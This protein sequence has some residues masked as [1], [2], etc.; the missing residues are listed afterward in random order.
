MED[1]QSPGKIAILAG[2][3]IALGVFFDYLFYDKPPGI[4]FLIFSIIILIALA[5]IIWLLKRPFLAS[6]W[7]YAIPIVFFSGMVAIREAYFLSFLNI[8]LT[9][10]LFLLLVDRT[11]GKDLRA[12]A[13][14][15]YLAAGAAL[16]LKIIGSAIVGVT[17]VFAVRTK[18]KGHQALG[19]VVRGVLLA[20][21]V[22]IILLLLFASADLIFKKYLTDLFDIQIEAETFFY[23]VRILFVGGVLFG[24]FRIIAGLQH[25]S[26]QEVVSSR[27]KRTLGMI[28]ISVFLGII[29]AAFL[30][31]IAVQLA[32]L[33]GGEHNIAVQGYTYAEY[34]RKGFF[35]LIAAAVLT[36]LALW[37]AERSIAKTEEKHARVFQ[38]L[39]AGLG[40]Q[41]F[42]MMISAF[43][44]LSL[45]EQAYG[46]TNLRLYSHVA[47]VWI[48]CIFVFL[49]IHI[50]RNEDEPKFAFRSFVSVLLF[51]AFL[52][53]MN[54]DAFIARKN[55]E[56]FS[57]SGKLDASYLM[58]LSSDAVPE[59]IKI[60]D[61][62][63]SCLISS[64]VQHLREVGEYWQSLNLSRSNALR[65][66]DR[67]PSLHECPSE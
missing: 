11:F 52:N 53:F 15:N 63:S 19:S 54:P 23:L 16:P 28:E 21:P 7:L 31:F 40:L 27:P 13:I 67:N 59:I 30:T 48:A 41:V 61:V 25:T 62:G 56:R 12:Y 37:G 24:A 43:K 42:I 46:F 29:N 58:G 39:S 5:G 34:A 26:S 49:L 50:F 32:Y 35:E 14:I 22:V 2:V 47:I 36:L 4:S 66:L 57:P 3:A 44:R 65:L 17:D 38:W 51:V 33:F 64:K 20:V 18:L 55:I 45:Y 10:F 6:F 9:L 60:P 1:S 8:I